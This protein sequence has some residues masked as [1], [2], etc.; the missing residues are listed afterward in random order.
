MHVLHTQV[1]QAKGAEV[2]SELNQ[3][4][5]QLAMVT[6]RTNQNT[7]SYPADLMSASSLLEFSLKYDYDNQLYM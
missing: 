3:L 6:N 5:S 4:T 7:S 1:G 2:A